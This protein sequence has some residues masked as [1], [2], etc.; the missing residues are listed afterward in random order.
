MIT[1]EMVVLALLL[2]ALAVVA[3]ITHGD[4]VPEERRALHAYLSVD[5]HQA[6][7]TFAEDNGVSVT[8][9]LESQGQMLRLDIEAAPD[10]VDLLHRSWIKEARRIDAERRR[11]G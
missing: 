11:R 9:L 8:G 3:Q 6:W 7:M 10:D 4:E 2:T 1:V 5:A